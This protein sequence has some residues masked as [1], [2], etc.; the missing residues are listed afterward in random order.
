MAHKRV[1]TTSDPP[2]KKAKRTNNVERHEED[3][4]PIKKTDASLSEPENILREILNAFS[5]EIERE[6]ACLTNIQDTLD[7]C[8]DRDAENFLWTVINYV[9]EKRNSALALVSEIS[10]ALQRIAEID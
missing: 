2:N 5:E 9:E 1:N 10:G 8:V 3:T 6:E 4:V 7:S